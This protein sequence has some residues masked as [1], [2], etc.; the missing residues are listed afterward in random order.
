MTSVSLVHALSY[1]IVFIQ[2]IQ[3]LDFTN[4]NFFCI[5]EHK[6]MAS[7]GNCPLCGSEIDGETV[8]IGEK[9]AEGINKA[10]IDRGDSVV[11]VPGTG[12]HKRCRVSYIN[13][14]QIHLFKKA[15]LQPPPPV[16]RSARNSVGPFNSTS[17]CLFCGNETIKS[18]G[19]TDFD[20]FS[21][22]KTLTR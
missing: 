12:V 11:V 9:G 20:E 2:P 18:P 15:K 3:V 21:C 22:L 6:K 14:K 10:S 19:S 8:V 17:H 1:V 16:K 7:R 4:I 13:K 5:S